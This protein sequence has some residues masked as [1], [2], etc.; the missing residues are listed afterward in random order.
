VIRRLPPLAAALL[1]ASL[2]SLTASAGTL[3]PPA[4]IPASSVEKAGWG[5]SHYP[6]HYHHSGYHGGR[7]GFWRHECD[8]QWSWN[9]TEYLL[10]LRRHACGGNDYYYRY[11][12]YY[13]SRDSYSEYYRY[14]DRY[15]DYYYRYRYRDRHYDYDD[16]D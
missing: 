14:R 13:R 3:P 6:Y 1:V 5:D 10:C 8:R 15:H 16:R 12:N 9:R 7:C 4:P 2:I 11:Y